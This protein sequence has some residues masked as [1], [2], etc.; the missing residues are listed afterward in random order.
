MRTIAGVETAE[1]PA[2]SQRYNA[3]KGEGIGPLL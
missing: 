3:E 2:G 1:A